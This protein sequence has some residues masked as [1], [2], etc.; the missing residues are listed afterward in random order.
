VSRQKQDTSTPGNSKTPLARPA[1][2]S[3]PLGGII[4]IMMIIMGHDHHHG[5]HWHAVW[6]TKHAI[7]KA[8][9]SLYNDRCLAHH[10]RSPRPLEAVK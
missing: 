4:M 6:K 2:D 9:Q 3:I 8:V 5:D 1:F 10:E 7:L